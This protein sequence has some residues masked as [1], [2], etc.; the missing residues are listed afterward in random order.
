M[1]KSRQTTRCEKPFTPRSYQA[2]QQYTAE[3]QD[4]LQTFNLITSFY[5]PQT[6]SYTRSQNPLNIVHVWGFLGAERKPSVIHENYEN[7]FKSHV[8]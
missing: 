2:F 7:K 4:I 6:F 3:H 5:F 1:S 8:R